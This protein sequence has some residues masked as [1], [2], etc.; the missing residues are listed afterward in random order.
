MKEASK[1]EEMNWYEEERR[2]KA[3]RQ[4]QMNHGVQWPAAKEGKQKNDR[5]HG[6]RRK[7]TGRRKQNYSKSLMPQNLPKT[8][9]YQ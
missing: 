7:K 9:S 4:E 2:V 5:G 1:E 6:D 8:S 3:E